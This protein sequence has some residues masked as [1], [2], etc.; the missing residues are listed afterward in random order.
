MKPHTDVLCFSK[1]GVGALQRLYLHDDE[2][3]KCVLPLRLL[4][5]QQ[6]WGKQYNASLGSGQ[7]RAELTFHLNLFAFPDNPSPPLATLPGA[8]EDRFGK[9]IRLLEN[10]QLPANIIGF[11]QVSPHL[12]Q[13]SC[14]PFR[15]PIEPRQLLTITQFQL[16]SP[17]L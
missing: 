13:Y 6:P 11:L 5:E 14:I 12:P 15:R 17:T 1:L 4:I 9:E 7:G 8:L 10:I 16:I 2:I 3:G